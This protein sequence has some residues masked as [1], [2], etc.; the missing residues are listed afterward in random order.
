MHRDVLGCVGG[1][2]QAEAEVGLSRVCVELFD[3]CKEN[4]FKRNGNLTSP[5]EPYGFT[6]EK[7]EVV[8]RLV[9]EKE[10]GFVNDHVRSLLQRAL[11]N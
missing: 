8:D 5:I 1:E 2:T 3:V 4:L 10:K 6:K 7:Q 9:D 11:R